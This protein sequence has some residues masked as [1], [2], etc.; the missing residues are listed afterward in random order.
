MNSSKLSNAGKQEGDQGHPRDTDLEG[1]GH[2]TKYFQ[3]E[4]LLRKRML[5]KKYV[6]RTYS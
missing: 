5:T 3:G 1:S 2:A 4:L 6:K